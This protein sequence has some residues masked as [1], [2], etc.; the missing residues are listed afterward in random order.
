MALPER[1][2]LNPNFPWFPGKIRG[3]GLAFDSLHLIARMISMRKL[4]RVA[5]LF[6]FDGG[7]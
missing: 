5:V 2:L 4:D 6:F 3:R 7:R 1:L